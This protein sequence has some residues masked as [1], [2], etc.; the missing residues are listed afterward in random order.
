MQAEYA[1]HGYYIGEVQVDSG[2]M[3]SKP[4]WMHVEFIEVTGNKKQ[5]EARNDIYQSVIDN[6]LIRNDGCA[7]CLFKFGRKRYFVNME[8]YAR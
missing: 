3:A 6:W 7:P 8:V 2:N 4:V 5:T 1:E